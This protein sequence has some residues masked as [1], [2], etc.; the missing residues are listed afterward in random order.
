MGPSLV[1]SVSSYS[2][3]SFLVSNVS[4]TSLF[5]SIIG[6]TYSQ[7]TTFSGP[8]GKARADLERLCTLGDELLADGNG[9]LVRRT[10]VRSKRKVSSRKDP[11]GTRINKPDTRRAMCDVVDKICTM[12]DRT[13]KSGIEILARTCGWRRCPP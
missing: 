12:H 13:K 10:C 8:T 6:A 3:Y 7:R 1:E 2:G 5:C 9:P 4:K 11:Q